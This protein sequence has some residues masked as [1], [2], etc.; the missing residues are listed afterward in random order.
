MSEWRHKAMT[1]ALYLTIAL[2]SKD[3]NTTQT[4]IGMV[5]KY[6]ICF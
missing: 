5:L 4:W 6:G 1:F 3:F 2:E